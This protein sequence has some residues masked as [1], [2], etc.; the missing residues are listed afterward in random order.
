MQNLQKYA[1]NILEVNVLSGENHVEP[2]CPLI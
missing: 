1:L 2:W